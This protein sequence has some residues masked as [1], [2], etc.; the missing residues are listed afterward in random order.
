MGVPTQHPTLGSVSFLS[1]WARVDRERA[2][3][4]S[5]AQRGTSTPEVQSLGGTCQPHAKQT[6]TATCFPVSL[7]WINMSDP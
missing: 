6:L 4:G 1:A 7:Y 3:K 5:Q 2:A